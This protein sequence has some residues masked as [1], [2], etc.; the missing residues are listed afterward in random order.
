M[1]VT[2]E[3]CLVYLERFCKGFDV[4]LMDDASSDPVTLAVID[5]WRPFFKQVFVNTSPKEGKRHGNLY[6][7]IMDM[8][9]YALANGYPY[10]MMVQD[11]MQ[12]VRPLTDEIL[13]QYQRIFDASD[14]VLQVDPRFVRNGNFA[15]R[16]DI[17]T[18]RLTSTTS[19][20]DV[21]VTHLARFK[22][23][24]WS[25][26]DS[27]RANQRGLAELGYERYFPFTPVA[28]H[29]P[30]PQ[31]YRKGKRRTSLLL[32][33]RGKYG[34]HAMSEED[35]RNMDQRDLATIPYFKKFLRIRNMHF[36]RILYYLRKDMR[37]FT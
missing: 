10:L 12:F 33:N 11:D 37:I 30:F 18:Y 7:N 19:Y 24:G 14:K 8:F 17:R 9:D 3:N 32:R 4:V 1:G 5:K 34:Y 23:S 31:I 25:L 16:T 6:Q 35:M 27:E 20:A 36:S 21:G 26:K 28:M 15:V 2:L 13:A 22:N 29:V